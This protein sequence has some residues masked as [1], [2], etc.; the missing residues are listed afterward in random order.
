MHTVYSVY[1]DGVKLKSFTN[2]ADAD[3]FRRSV[4]GIVKE[5][6]DVAVRDEISEL[7]TQ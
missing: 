1:V 5:T 7:A 2:E 4:A 3:A 6:T